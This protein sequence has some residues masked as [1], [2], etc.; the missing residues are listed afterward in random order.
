MA[1]VIEAYSV[2]VRNAT[3]ETKY[4]GGVP[5]YQQD[6]PNATFCSDNNLCRIA[7]M[8]HKDAE[9]FV[10]Q[11]AAKGLTPSRKGTAED[12][13]LVS[14][15]EGTSGSCEWLEVI[16]SE[17]STVAWL[18]GTQPG[19]VYAPSG[20]KPDTSLR[21]FSPEEIK[22]RLEF[23]RVQGNVDVYRDKLT[24]KEL[25]TGRTSRISQAD[26][27]RHEKLY[28]EAVK[29]TEGLLLLDDGASASLNPSNR[30]RLGKAIELFKEVIQIH[31][32]NWAAMW[33]LGKVY[34]RLE[35]FPNGLEW[36]TRAH[37]TNPDQPDVAREAAI[38]AMDSDRPGEAVVFCER[39][40]E[41][42]PNDPGLRANLA[43][44]LL[45]S[46]KPKDAQLVAMDAQKR[47]PSDQITAQLLRIIEEVLWGARPCPHHMRD[48]QRRPP[49]KKPWWKFW[50]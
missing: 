2:V 26:E 38:A 18:S 29:L 49:A 14:Q 43:L 23:V 40:I 7:F 27:E 50:S 17:Q 5:Q 33:L 1:V 37:R 11:L 15:Y 47:A 20:W 28:K 3:V 12:V 39:A 30:Q 6:C 25:Y 10:A 24:G 4:P 41:A 34:Q 21:Q 9:H 46:G 44:A 45:F 42:N 22:E 13:A 35:D 36:F 19:D 48:V 16:K 8:A 32:G 31:P